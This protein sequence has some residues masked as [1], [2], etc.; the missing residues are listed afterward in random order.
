MFHFNPS[1]SIEFEKEAKRKPTYF[2]DPYQYLNKFQN[3]IVR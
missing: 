3:L 1:G 2:I